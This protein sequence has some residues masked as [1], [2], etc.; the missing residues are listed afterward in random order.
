MHLF[1]SYARHGTI[2]R[3][4]LFALLVAS[5][6]A[7]AQTTVWTDGTGNWFTPANWSAGVPNANTDAL[8]NNGGNAQITSSGAA[9]GEVEIG[10]GVQDSGTLSTSGSGD[11]QDGGLLFTSEEAAR[12]ISVLQMAVLFLA[13][14]LS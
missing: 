1:V 6:P 9:A 7:F 8:I 14:V 3:W 10:V 5:A 12:A 2:A 13:Y 11:L 4:A